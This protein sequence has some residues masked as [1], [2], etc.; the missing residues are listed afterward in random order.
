MSLQSNLAELLA[1]PGEVPFNE[2]RAY[3]I[4]V[5]QEDA[6]YRFVDGE[7]LERFLDSSEDVQRKAVKGLDTDIERVRG[8]LEAL[9]RMH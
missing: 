4:Q 7:F 2:S 5:R 1:G 9:R 6:P 8:L 3:N